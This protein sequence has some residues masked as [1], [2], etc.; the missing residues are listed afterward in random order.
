MMYGISKMPKVGSTE[1]ITLDGS[2][3]W[4]WPSFSFCSSSVSLPSWEEPKTCTSALSPRSALA[5]RANSLALASNSE[6]GSP[7]WPNFRLRVCAT[8]GLAISPVTATALMR[9]SIFI[10]ILPRM[11]LLVVVVQRRRPVDSLFGGT[12]RQSLVLAAE[13]AEGRLHPPA[14]VGNAGQLEP[15][16]H[17][18]EGAHEH[19]IVEVAE[20]AD[21]EHLVGDL[22]G[23]NGRG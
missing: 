8:A 11:R 15:H 18:G 21:A 12:L 6:P 2:A 10:F 7:T 17:A 20:G 13:I 1:D 16:L 9:P 14:A 4:T 19:E 23:E 5:Q 22:G 3:N